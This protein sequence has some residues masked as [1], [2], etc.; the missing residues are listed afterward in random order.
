MV[1]AALVR[2]MLL[3]G[4]PLNEE[5]LQRQREE[6]I[7]GVFKNPETTQIKSRDAFDDESI[8]VCQFCC[9]AGS[10]EIWC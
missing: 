4:I 9:K 5:S 2:L 3:D 10:K 7:Y 8:P 1:D 6:M